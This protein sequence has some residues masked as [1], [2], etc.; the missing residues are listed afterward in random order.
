MQ[1]NML[2]SCAIGC[3]SF[4]LFYGMI[5]INNKYKYRIYFLGFWNYRYKWY[6]ILHI[7]IAIFCALVPLFV[8]VFIG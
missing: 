1:I 5:L 2:T 4:G 7:L 8:M 6:F 3:I